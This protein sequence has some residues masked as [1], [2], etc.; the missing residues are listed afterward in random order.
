VSSQPKHNPGVK[1]DQQ[2]NSRRLLPGGLAAVLVLSSLVA[3]CGRGPAPTV[4]VQSPVDTVYAFF[5]ALNSGD[6][7]LVDAHLA[8]DSMLPLEGG[9]PPRDL[10]A[11]VTCRLG[12]QVTS[13]IVDSDTR[14]VVACEFDVRDYWSGFSAGHHGWGVWLEREPPGPWLIHDWGVPIGPW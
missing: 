10:F 8:P 3:G 9:A 12:S 11:N 1:K 6:M 2:H 7:Q 4:A 5:R 14:A 13:D